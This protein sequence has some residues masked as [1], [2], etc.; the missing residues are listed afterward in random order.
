LSEQ[1]NYSEKVAEVIDDEIHTLI[2][3]AH[4]VARDVLSQNREKLVQIAERLVQDETM[5]GEALEELFSS[6]TAAEEFSGV[7]S[8]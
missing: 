4:Q 1:R 6:P 3:D 2:E 5:E 8:G 7:S